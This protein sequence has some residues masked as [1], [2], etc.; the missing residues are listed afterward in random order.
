LLDA[1]ATHDAA[2]NNFDFKLIVISKVRL[3]FFDHA[4][5]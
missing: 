1:L 2:N 4:G 3:L 5:S